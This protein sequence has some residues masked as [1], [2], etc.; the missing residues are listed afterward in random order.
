MGLQPLE[1]SIMNSVLHVYC[2]MR[3]GGWTGRRAS[4]IVI[5]NSDTDLMT[6]QNP[7]RL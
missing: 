7:I 1:I 6:R 5:A 4:A 3:T 2:K